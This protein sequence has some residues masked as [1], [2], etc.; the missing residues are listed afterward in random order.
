MQNL[1]DHKASHIEEWEQSVSEFAG[2][3]PELPD[4]AKKI[5][6]EERRRAGFSNSKG[7]SA[8]MLQS[9]MQSCGSDY[10]PQ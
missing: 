1:T 7:L 3:I 10:P 8:V 2:R 9:K 4:A 5:I 6:D